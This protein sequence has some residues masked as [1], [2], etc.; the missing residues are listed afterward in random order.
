VRFLQSH[1]GTG[2]GTGDNNQSFAQQL[3][4]ISGVGEVSDSDSISGD[5]YGGE[6]GGRLMRDDSACDGSVVI[7]RMKASL[8]TRLFLTEV[9]ARDPT[10]V[11]MELAE[12]L[13]SNKCKCE[14]SQDM[15]VSVN[16]IINV[17]MNYLFISTSPFYL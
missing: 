7:V 8:M 15:N 13:I 3:P 4:N 17:K 14:N 9:R 16:V 12:V 10:A 2:S 5:D 1:S 6:C 11:R